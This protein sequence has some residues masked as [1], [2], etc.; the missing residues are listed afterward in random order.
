[1]RFSSTRNMRIHV[2][3]GG[4]SRSS[5]RSTAIENTSSFDSGDA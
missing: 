3:R 2:A 5:S 1:M 4:T